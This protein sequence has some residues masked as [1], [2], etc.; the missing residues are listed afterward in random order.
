MLNKKL[1]KKY[2]TFFLSFVIVMIM[3]SVSSAKDVYLRAGV[4]IKTMP[5]GK[6]ITMGG[7]AQDSAFGAMDGKITVPG[8]VIRI[9]ANDNTLT[10]H[11]DNNLP[12]P[13]SIVIPGQTAAMTPVKFT[14]STGRQ[15]VM[16]L[17]H[18]TPPGN[19]AQVDYVWNNIKP[20]TYLYQSGTHQAV[21][22]QMGLYG[23]VKKDAAFKRA[24]SNP[25]TAYD[26]EV[27]LVLSEIDPALHDAVATNNY[28]PGKAMTSTI[29]YSPK[30]FLVNGR[31]FSYSRSPIQVVGNPGE[32]ILLRFLNA[33]LKDHVLL[34]QG[35]YMTVF[36][37]DGNLYPYAKQ[38]YSLVLPAGKT[39]D[40]MIIPTSAGYIPIYDRRLD[41]TNAKASPGG[42]LIYLR[43]AS[44]TEH[45]L[46]VNKAG[47]GNGTVKVTSL[48]GGVYCGKNCTE[49]YNAG[50]VVA[51]TA[52]PT[53]G[54]AF[55]GW[56]GDATGT[57]TIVTVTMDAAKTVTA[58]FMAAP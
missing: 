44:A 22:V 31:P 36:S 52:I 56:S 35:T 8:P 29:N 27:I 53:A 34:T 38:Q 49:L 16:S 17:T 15:R 50:T 23:A 26:R 4:T 9:P 54:S 19:T 40:S 28:G 14:D 18:E 32:R 48:P 37:E 51:L 42:M 45:L 11:L 41:L 39:K 21:Q 3:V 33:G 5:D 10:I 55:T 24:Y 57:E 6:K 46:T 20:G 2:K 7:F 12:V 47:T 25:S 43:I 13:V 1:P 58:T 30:Y